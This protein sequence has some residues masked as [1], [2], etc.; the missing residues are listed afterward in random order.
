MTSLNDFG[1]NMESAL[2]HYVLNFKANVSHDLG[3][4]RV[5]AVAMT[6]RMSETEEKLAFIARTRRARAARFDTQKPMLTILGIDQG[7][8]KQY[9]TRTPLPHRFIPKFCAATGV[10]IEW[11]LTGEG[12]G[13]KEEMIPR[14][15]QVRR[16]RKPGQKAA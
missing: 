5:E 4:G 11:L 10:D 7:T 9:E 13:P 2:G 16:G 6:D 14:E 3:F 1:S 12:K 15:V 8:Y